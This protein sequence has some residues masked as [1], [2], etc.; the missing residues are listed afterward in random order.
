MSH[1]VEVKTSLNSK[2]YIAD[3]L[4][5]MGYEITV[6]K[7]NEELETR[8]SYNNG[9]SKV[10]ILINKAKGN[11]VNGEVGFAKQEDGTYSIIGDFWNTGL[12]ENQLAGDVQVCAK[13]IET[14]ERLA[15]LGFNLTSESNQGH[16]LELNFTRYA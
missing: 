9:K 12:T 5:E 10:E 13:K 3:A 15:E 16:D 1:K 6:A 4:T 2:K 14:C 7:D 8:D 11:S